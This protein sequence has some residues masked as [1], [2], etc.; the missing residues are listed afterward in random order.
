MAMIRK[1]V[2]YI[3]KARRKHV[4][5]RCW[6]GRNV[7][8]ISLDALSSPVINNTSL[9]LHFM[10][11]PDGRKMLSYTCSCQMVSHSIETKSIHFYILTIKSRLFLIVLSWYILFYKLYLFISEDLC[12]FAILYSSWIT[13]DDVIRT[14]WACTHTGNSINKT[15]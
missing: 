9:N 3:G 5:N 12:V 15:K 14:N 4:F 10:D 13:R 11:I 7:V 6:R 1:G 2:F 8:V